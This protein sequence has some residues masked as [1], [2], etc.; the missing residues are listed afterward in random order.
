MKSEQYSV[1]NVVSIGPLNVDRGSGSMSTNAT[2][3]ATMQNYLSLGCMVAAKK[4]EYASTSGYT[5]FFDYFDYF[6]K[7]IN[8]ECFTYVSAYMSPFNCGK[9][10]IM[11]HFGRVFDVNPISDAIQDAIRELWDWFPYL[12]QVQTDVCSP[13][14]V[15]TDTMIQQAITS[16]RRNMQMVV[17]VFFDPILGVLDG[18]DV[19]E[20]TDNGVGSEV[21]SRSSSSG[22]SESDAL[23]ESSMSE[24]NSDYETFVRDHDLPQVRDSLTEGEFD[25][26][27][28]PFIPSQSMSSS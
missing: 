22:S 2:I 23:S 11:K 24:G 27:H 18:Y 26:L 25:Q 1:V 5:Q 14:G 13:T 20:F 28:Q 17:G 19:G 16:G 6:F 10:L 7:L 8:T 3:L 9:D 21:S 4:G 12:Q 15:I